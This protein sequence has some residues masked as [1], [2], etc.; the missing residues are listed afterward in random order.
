M[1]NIEPGTLI[2][3]KYKVLEHITQGSVGDQVYKGVHT[4]MEN[5]ILIRIM[6]PSMSMDKTLAKRFTQ[7]IKLTAQ[8]QHFNILMA[9]EAG[10]EAGNL[11]L[12]TAYEKGFFMR[13]FLEHRGKLPENEAIDMML[14]L[15]DAMDYAWENSKIVHRN[16]RPE[17]IL[18]ARSNHPMIT[19]F[20]M[21][22]PMENRSE[23]LTMAG[24]TIGNPQYMSPEQV[25]GESGLDFRADM[26]CLGLIFYETLAGHAAFTYK[27]QIQLM[28]AQVNELPPPLGKEN[29]DISKP[30][31]KVAEKMLKKDR[32][33]RYLSWSEL[34]NDLK[35]LK[36]GSDV[37]AKTSPDSKKEAPAPKPEKKPEKKEKSKKKSLSTAS[38]KSDS[39]RVS[40]RQQD[41]NPLVKLALVGFTI[42][43]LLICA[44]VVY[45]IISAKNKAQ[46]K[47]KTD[48]IST[49]SE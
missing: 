28:D 48:P 8:L 27:S 25:S 4:E 20:G 32:D 10:E 15:C 44:Y 12:I 2:K 21:A 45:S 36:E 33:E 40:A 34:I 3:G 46:D 37:S 43:V 22:K 13:E 26:Y 6:P 16:I 11:F 30:C 39:R 17:T 19:D 1:D 7:Q 31:V 41:E 5:E 47:E 24:F 49:I 35:H 14:E 18:I 29:L 23:E 42:V 38:K 9:Y